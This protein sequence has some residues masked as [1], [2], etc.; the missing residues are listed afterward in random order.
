MLWA[1]PR[2]RVRTPVLLF[3]RFQIYK[4]GS[5]NDSRFRELTRF[6][7]NMTS[8]AKIAYDII[9]VSSSSVNSGSALDQTFGRHRPRPIPTRTFSGGISGNATTHIVESGRVVFGD[10]RRWRWRMT[11]DKGPRPNSQNG[12]TYALSPPTDTEEDHLIIDKSWQLLLS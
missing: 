2:S 7:E 9:R 10:P 8:Y 4:F 5:K 6:S 11:H 3:S 1:C 12:K